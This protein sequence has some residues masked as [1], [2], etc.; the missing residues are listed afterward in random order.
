MENL[1]SM[2][3]T[4]A[5]AVAAVA[6]VF[7]AVLFGVLQKK[8]ADNSQRIALFDKRYDIYKAS[9]DLFEIIRFTSTN[10]SVVTVPQYLV[11]ANMVIESYELMKGKE[12]LVEHLRLK[13]VVQAASKEE[14]EQADR[15][16]FYLDWYAQNRL[17]QLR[18]KIL[19]QIKPAKFCFNE[20]IYMCLK[21]TVEEFFHYILLFRN[22]SAEE[23]ERD[24]ALL[25]KYV[26][27]IE[28]KKV[29]EEMESYLE[30]AKR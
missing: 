19:A 18:S 4:I 29:F 25:N 16:L 1:V 12:F 20:E 30:I 23:K 28:G 22:G 8:R 9:V 11:V 17:L 6:S 7:I 3:S 21:R 24:S 15:D 5:S 2:I 10:D 26:A 13:R 14:S 27:E